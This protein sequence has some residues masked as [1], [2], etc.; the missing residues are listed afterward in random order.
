MR[1]IFDELVHISQRK[2]YIVM[3]MIIV[4][5]L[6]SRD[7]LV[8]IPIRLLLYPIQHD[9]SHQN[10]LYL[11]TDIPLLPLFRLHSTFTLTQ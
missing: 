4:Y 11:T 3:I 8:L 6:L 5:D 9:K 7:M 2:L 1:V 10:A